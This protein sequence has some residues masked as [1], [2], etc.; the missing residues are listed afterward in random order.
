MFRVAT[1]ALTCAAL[2]HVLAFH[3]ADAC[4]PAFIFQ[5]SSTYCE[6]LQRALQALRASPLAALAAAVPALQGR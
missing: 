4:K 6:F 5:S 1:Y 2:H 3:Y